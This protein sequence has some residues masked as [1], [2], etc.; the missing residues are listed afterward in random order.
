MSNNLFD[1]QDMRWATELT[2]LSGHMQ[3]M[4]EQL[5]LIRQT[6]TDNTA[7][8]RT[9]EKALERLNTLPVD[10]RDLWNELREIEA[11]QE[12]HSK[13][14]A[15]QRTQMRLVLW[16]GGAIAAGALS[17]IIVFLSNRF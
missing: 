1:S 17:Q 9:M 13:M 14:F 8:I 15:E 6:Q 2:K 3:A 10:H 7:A 5:A 11:E 4:A 12:E 16:F